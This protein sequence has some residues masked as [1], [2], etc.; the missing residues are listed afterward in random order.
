MSPPR[1]HA[2]A[3]RRRRRRP[4]APP[5]ARFVAAPSS[6]HRAAAPPRLDLAA[7]EVARPRSAI[8]S[9][10]RRGRRSAVR[11]SHGSARRL[12]PRHPVGDLRW[13]L[14][15]IY[16]PQPPSSAGRRRRRSGRLSRHPPTSARDDAAVSDECRSV[17]ARSAGAAGIVGA[18]R[19]P[20]RSCCRSTAA[21]RRSARRAR[22]SCALQEGGGGRACR[23]SRRAVEITK[24]AA[25][26][27]VSSSRRGGLGDRGAAECKPNER[28]RSSAGRTNAIAGGACARQARGRCGQPKGPAAAHDSRPAQARLQISGRGR[29]A[30]LYHNGNQE[31]LD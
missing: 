19:S 4:C 16:D 31:S 15:C 5:R 27:H 30:S 8:R 22:R 13:A 29:G 23:P 25:A 20:S 24:T 21:S 3:A 12:R 9:A 28:A 18:P 10:G 11:S 7:V 6:R 2:A 14:H 17:R 1:R 26:R